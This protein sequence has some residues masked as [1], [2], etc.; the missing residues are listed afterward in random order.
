[1]A[2]QARISLPHHTYHLIQRG[3]NRQEIFASDEDRRTML[4]LLLEASRK[5]EVAV[6]SYVLMSNHVHLLVT[7]TTAEGMPLMMQQVGRSYVRRFNDSQGRSGTLFE[8]RY[9]SSLVQTERYL[10]ACMTYIDLNP[11]RAHICA[12]PQNFRWSSYSHYSGGLP[13]RL[14]T[15][16]PHFFN[17]G[18]TPFAREQAYAQLVQQGLAQALQENI[19]RSLIKNHGLGD[20]RFLHTLEQQTNRRLQPGRKGRPF[21]SESKSKNS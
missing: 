16:H 18:N 14:V 1:M 8:G 4:H 17:L 12:E 2:R 10:L 20:E 15:P 7:P 19:T 5:H 9:R 11:V 13:D 6:H 21:G 3:N